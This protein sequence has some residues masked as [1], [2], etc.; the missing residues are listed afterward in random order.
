MPV[1]AVAAGGAYLLRLINAATLSLLNVAVAGHSLTIV[2]A[3]GHA[4]VPL[5]VSSVDADS[6]QR[7]GVFLYKVLGRAGMRTTTLRART[8]CLVQLLHRPVF[9]KCLAKHPRETVGAARLEQLAVED[10]ANRM[11]NQ[12]LFRKC[13]PE[14]LEHLAPIP[15]ELSQE[16]SNIEEHAVKTRFGSAVAQSWRTFFLRT[17]FGPSFAVH[18]AREIKVGSCPRLPRLICARGRGRPR[19]RRASRSSP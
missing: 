18:C 2:G 11:K 9:T 17:A 8:P 10:E 16:L 5:A 1:F 19:S 12:L 6:G 14:S 15:Q 13:S 4:T 7:V 3:G